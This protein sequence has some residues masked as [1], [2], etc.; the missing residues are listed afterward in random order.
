MATITNSSDNKTLTVTLPYNVTPDKIYSSTASGNARE[1]VINQYQIIQLGT[2]FPKAIEWWTEKY[3]GLTL[4]GR[5]DSG[6]S[7]IVRFVNT[8]SGQGKDYFITT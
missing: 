8:S 4:R 5:G 6:Y 1:G 2:I 7:D 3:L